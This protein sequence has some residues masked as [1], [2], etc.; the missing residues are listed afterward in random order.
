MFVSLFVEFIYNMISMFSS[1]ILC[2]KHQ[3][4][5]FQIWMQNKQVSQ[6]MAR[7]YLMVTLSKYANFLWNGYLMFAHCIL[8]EIV[9][10]HLRK[11]VL[12]R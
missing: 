1:L 10:C 8:S 6:L 5:S 7:L 9:C 3:F 12:I 11:S 4:S 2:V